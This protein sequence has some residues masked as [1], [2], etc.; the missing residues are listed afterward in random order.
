MGWIEKVNDQQ[1]LGV[2]R[3]RLQHTRHDARRIAGE[4]RMRRTDLFQLAED[5]QLQVEVF[6]HGFNHE[7]GVAGSIPQVAA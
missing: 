2:A 7:I 4:N 6:G 5:I 1:A 3:G